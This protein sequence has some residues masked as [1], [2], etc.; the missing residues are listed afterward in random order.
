MQ[1]YKTNE[2]LRP[3]SFG[4]YS[5]KQRELSNE[6]LLLKYK[7][8]DA[9]T[10]DASSKTTNISPVSKLRERV[11][12]ISHK[13]DSMNINDNSLLKSGESISH[14]SLDN[15]TV[16]EVNKKNNN[17]DMETEMIGSDEVT[18]IERDNITQGD[19]LNHI[20]ALRLKHTRILKMSDSE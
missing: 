4:I 7:I 5:I 2:K 17:K 8:I 19:T 18:D 20:K 6:C 15:E 9:Q 3:Q 13:V 12:N 16:S 11:R 14:T 1:F 10:S